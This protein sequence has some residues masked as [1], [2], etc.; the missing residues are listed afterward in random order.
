[1]EHAQEFC[2]LTVRLILLEEYSIWNT[3]H[4]RGIKRNVKIFCYKFER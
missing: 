1:V 2:N 4:A 3:L